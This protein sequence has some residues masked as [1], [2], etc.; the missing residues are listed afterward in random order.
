MLCLSISAWNIEVSSSWLLKYQEEFLLLLTILNGFTSPCLQDLEVEVSTDKSD[1]KIDE[2]SAN[3]SDVTLNHVRTVKVKGIIDTKLEMELIKFV[4]AKSPVLVRMLIEPD[5]YS[6][7]KEKGI[8]IL[9]EL[10]AFQR[11][12]RKAEIECQ[13]ER[14]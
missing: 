14:K 1:D 6:V 5:L 8:K 10:S 7:N 12:S 13:L 11:A 3:F 2:V 9:A 4:L